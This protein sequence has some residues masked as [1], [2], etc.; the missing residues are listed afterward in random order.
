M[1]GWYQGLFYITPHLARVRVDASSRVGVSQQSSHLAL[2]QRNLSAA[3]RRPPGE[4]KGE[5]VRK[6]TG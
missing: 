2:V 5:V 4:L 3:R 6:Y 1:R